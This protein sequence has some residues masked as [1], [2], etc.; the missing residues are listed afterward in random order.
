MTWKGDSTTDPEIISVGLS[1]LT[2]LFTS[3]LF[4]EDPDICP[5]LLQ[6]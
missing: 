3:A 5:T 6:Q 2:G 1:E 4:P